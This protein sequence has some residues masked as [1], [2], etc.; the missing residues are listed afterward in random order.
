MSQKYTCVSF[1][2]VVLGESAAGKTSILL[3]YAKNYFTSTI[4]P[5]IGASNFQKTVD[6]GD[7]KIKLLVW[8]TAGQERFHSLAKMYYRG[9][10]GAIIV[11]DCTNLNSFKKAKL[12]VEEI[13]KEG[14]PNVKIALVGNKIDLPNKQVNIK[15]A[16]KFAEENELLFFQTSAK[17]GQGVVKAFTGLA[18]VLPIQFGDIVEESID[19][20]ELKWDKGNKSSQNG[21]SDGCC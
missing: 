3:R 2:V 11:Y 19:N 20:L 12:W 18:K 1:K 16:K 9:A 13:K 8:D 15:K 6:L 7:Y 14:S 17:T 5:T 4:E 10:K 21:K